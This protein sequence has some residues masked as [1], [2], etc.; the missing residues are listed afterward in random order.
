MARKTEGATRR[1]DVQPAI[2]CAHED[3]QQYA[4][5]NLRLKTGWAKLCMPHYEQHFAREGD[6]VTTAHGLDKL[7]EETREEWRKRVF[8]H[9]KALAGK[10]KRRM[11]NA[12]VEEKAA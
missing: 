6:K 11:V 9:W 10:M 3:C 12:P 5:V 8:A 4:V 7:P 1:E 2:P